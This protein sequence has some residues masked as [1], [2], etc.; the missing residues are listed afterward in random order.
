MTTKT[1]KEKKKNTLE[2]SSGILLLLMAP[3]G[4][5]DGGKNSLQRWQYIP[6]AARSWKTKALEGE[7][8]VVRE[9]RE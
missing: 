1:G 8:E 7:A 2:G 5:P 9:E 3:K 4:K 6:G